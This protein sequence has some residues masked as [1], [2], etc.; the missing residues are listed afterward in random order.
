MH[1]IIWLS[2][3]ILASMT[4][5]VHAQRIESMQ[6]FSTET[7]DRLHLAGYSGTTPV[8]LEAMVV[9]EANTIQVR[10]PEPGWYSVG[11]RWQTDVPLRVPERGDYRILVCMSGAIC[12]DEAALLIFDAF[13][14]HDTNIFSDAFEH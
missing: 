12:N 6:L 8:Y 11:M 1:R 10:F 4:C 5:D 9:I 13:L 3:L 14:S 7:E 2:L